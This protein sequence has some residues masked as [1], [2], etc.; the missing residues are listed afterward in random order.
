MQNIYEQVLNVMKQFPQTNKR[1]RPYQVSSS[2][3]KTPFQSYTEHNNTFKL[4]W[5]H[6]R[7]QAH[8]HKLRDAQTSF[9]THQNNFKMSTTYPANLHSQERLKS[10]K[11]GLR[12]RAWMENLW[13]T[14]EEILL[15]M[16]SHGG[17]PLPHLCW[18]YE[19]EH[20]RQR[21]KSNCW[22]I[23]LTYKPLRIHHSTFCSLN[24]RIL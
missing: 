19:A 16:M 5:G 24:I 11:P 8:P 14:Q 4:K 22:N 10:P 3:P 6:C 23:N 7:L 13:G 15:L 2:I 17:N 18:A 1:T 21:R 12:K 20:R 9:R